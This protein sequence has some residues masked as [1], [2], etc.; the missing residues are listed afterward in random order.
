MFRYQRSLFSLTTKKSS[1]VRF[2]S[3]SVGN[4]VQLNNSTTTTTT[5]TT[6]TATAAT[7]DKEVI[8]TKPTDSENKKI[9]FVPVINIPETE[10]AHNAFFSL[11][12]PLLGLSDENE[13]PFFAQKTLQS[14]E[15]K[16]Q[17]KLDVMLAMYMGNCSPFLEP[18]QLPPQTQGDEWKDGFSEA[19]DDAS[20]ETREFTVTEEFQDYQDIFGQED[21]AI[22]TAVNTT[23][24][25]LPMFHMPEST[26][27]LDYLSSIESNMKQENAK[28]DAQDDLK[29][30]RLRKFE[31]EQH[32]FDNHLSVHLPLVS[33]HHHVS[34]KSSLQ[35]DNPKELDSISKIPLNIG[36]LDNILFVSTL[37]RVQS[38]TKKPMTSSSEMK[39]QSSQQYMSSG[40]IYYSNRRLSQPETHHQHDYYNSSSSCS[41]ELIRRFSSGSTTSTVVT[42]ISSTASLPPLV[43][44]QTTWETVEAHYNPTAA[45]VWADPI[46]VQE[47]PTRFE[48][49]TSYLRENQISFSSSL[50]LLKPCTFY[51]SDTNIKQ[52]CYI[53][54]VNAV[55]QCDT[56]WQFSSRW[57]LYKQT[58][59][60]KPSQLLP[61]QNLFC[62]INGVEPMWEDKVNEKGGRLTITIQNNGKHLDDVSEWIICALVGGGIYDYGVVGIV[63]SKRNRGDRIELWLDESN[64]T[65]QSIS[66]FKYVIKH[67][68]LITSSLLI[69]NFILENTFVLYYLLL[70]T[71]KL[72]QVDIK[73]IFNKNIP[74]CVNT[75]IFISVKNKFLS[76]CV[77]IKKTLLFISLNKKKTYKIKLFIL[78][79]LLSLHTFSF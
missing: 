29:A 52:H 56:V 54:A 68:L 7:V 20:K 65:N 48:E 43:D 32:M 49:A 9:A 38:S 77:Y 45:P 50:P 76:S 37:T 64:T 31:S 46:K 2:N 79:S 61:N 19:Y 51:F 66:Q 5:T 55:F 78:L 13:T 58:Y 17:E 4:K 30:L 72:M 53:S 6:A 21:T 70:A 12:R 39:R 75:S 24:S 10:F 40:P 22:N 35:Q 36:G 67:N 28:L 3:S 34:L 59:S 69:L 63:V 42:S 11:Y 71:M 25:P 73:S 14:Q 18:S 15:E 27:V 8:A 23:T 60:K 62:F 26:D 41:T 47:N 1:L 33:A 16:D 74:Y 57:R 44:A